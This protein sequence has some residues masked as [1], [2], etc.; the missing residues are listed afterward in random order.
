M[1]HHLVN[2]SIPEVSGS[3]AK[4]SVVSLIISLSAALISTIWALYIDSFVG[5]VAK[6]GYLTAFL[7]FVS[8]FSYFFFIPLI[9]RADKGKLFVYS[10]I[11]MGGVYFLFYYVKSFYFFLA[12][13]VVFTISLVLRVMTFGIIV[14]DFSKKGELSRNEGLKYTFANIAF[15]I[16]PLTAAYI[17]ANFGMK[18]V[19][20]VAGVITL[21]GALFF[22]ES[23]M[24]DRKKAKKVNRDMIDNFFSFFRSKE[25]VVA[26]VLGGGVYFWGAL[27]YL[28]IPLYIVR[29]GLSESYVG[30]FLFAVA[31]PLIIFE[32]WFAKIAGRRGFKKMFFF[33]Y[34]IAGVLAIACFF[35]SGI[36]AILGLLV[37]GSVGLAM[38]EPTVEAYFF[39]ILNKGE[40][41]R[42]Y[43]PFNTSLDLNAFAGRVLGSTLLLFL[44]FKFIFLFFG[45]I[46]IFFALVSLGVRG[47]VEKR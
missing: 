9:Q 2:K 12:L 18:H 13:A 39:D 15:V 27:I 11:L 5:D 42:Y 1:G 8:F 40:E 21:I 41:Y 47:V 7:A 4:I 6:V 32:Y 34:F 19:F 14:K 36:Y 31:V 28:F 35:V 46:M 24:K 37:L 30:Y 16:G 20:V 10:L 17:L 26:Y 38:L 22:L 29:E 23:G 43:G 33:G 25:R 45:A 44:P 3:M